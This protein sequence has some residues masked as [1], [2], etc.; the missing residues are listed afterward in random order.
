M[1]LSRDGTLGCEGSN[2][3]SLNLPSRKHHFVI[4]MSKKIL[5]GDLHLGIKSNSVF[6]LESQID[7]FEKQVFPLIEEEKPDEVIFLGDVSDV[8]YS[9]NQQVG[10]EAKKLFRKMLDQ[11]KDTTF[12][13]IAGNHDYYSP[14]EE[15]QEYNFY[16]LVFGEEFMSL[17]KNFIVVDKDPMLLEDGSLLLPW[18]WTENPL[19]FDELLYHYDFKRDVKSIYCHADLGC[20]PG[21]RISALHGAPVYSGHIHYI[22]EDP[23]GNLYNVGACLALTFA[24]VNQPRYLYVVEDHKVTKKIENI[25]TPIFKRL[26]DEEIFNTEEKLF[27]NSY[28]QMCISRENI[29]KAKYIDRIKEIRSNHL[30]TNIRIHILDDDTNPD[31]LVAEGFSTN[32]SKYIEQNVPSHLNP[33]YEKIKERIKNS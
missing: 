19:H 9:I 27:D 2:Q 26:Y 17:H 12:I 5:I 20:W 25:T 15:L 3:K 33:K 16:E 14:L 18:Y 1:F 28:I 22:V 8:R 32:I 6:W 11:F 4:R 29:N 13:C 21:A 24:D 10:I 7:L 30:D 31:T 23:I